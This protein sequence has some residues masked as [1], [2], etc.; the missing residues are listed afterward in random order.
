MD[1]DGYIYFV[2]RVKDYIRRRGENISSFEVEKIVGSHHEIHECATVGI[3]AEGGRYAEDEVMIVV[4]AKKGKKVDPLKLIEYLEPRM[5]TFMLPRFIRFEV[6]LPKTGTERVQ[7]NK[8][9]DKGITKDTWDRE[10]AGYKV[11]R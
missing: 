4:V 6:S 1:K 5:P 8:L 11:K 3:K 2:D 10:K 7:K 9:R